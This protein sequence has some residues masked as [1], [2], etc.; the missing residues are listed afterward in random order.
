MRRLVRYVANSVF[1]WIML[2]VLVIVGMD[3]VFSLIDELQNLRGGYRAVEAMQ[4]VLMTIPK[5][6]YEYMS[7]S[8][9][10]GCLVGLGA[11]ANNSELT[12]MRASG[13]SLARISWAAIKPALVCVCISIAIGEYVVPVTENY[14][15]SQKAIAQSGNQAVKSRYGHWHREGST[16]MHFNAVEPGGKIHGITQY[17]FDDNRKL[18]QSVYAE[19]ALFQGDHWMLQKVVTTHL[20]ERQV[21]EGYVI[22]LRGHTEL[23]P[24]VLS[25]VVVEPEDLSIGGLFTYSIY[26]VEKGLDAKRYLLAYWKKVLQPL[27]TVVMVLVALSCI[28]GPLRTVTMGFRVFSGVIIG[29]LFRYT[30][31]FMGPASIVFGFAP[32]YASLIPVIVFLLL[33][34]ILLKR[35]G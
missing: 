8:V 2:A 7:L 30:E 33:A 19:T 11:L 32:I 15:Q 25:V 16:F 6:L 13:M 31:D 22:T 10:I 18:L 12:V 29:L 9:L 26:L 28:F 14:A 17:Q 23:A 1:D 35:A 24:A 34:G 20:G 4:Y 21:E 5:R 27:T 3:A